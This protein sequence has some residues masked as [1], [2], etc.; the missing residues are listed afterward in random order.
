MAFP[1][2]LENNNNS[3]KSQ[4]HYK[5]DN[6]GSYLIIHCGI[7]CPLNNSPQ[8]LLYN[9]SDCIHF[10]YILLLYNCK[11]YRPFEHQ[12]YYGYRQSYYGSIQDSRERNFS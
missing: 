11:L 1:L 2:Y 6:F 7:H 9:S 3:T 10:N 4:H 5:M 8:Y 12:I